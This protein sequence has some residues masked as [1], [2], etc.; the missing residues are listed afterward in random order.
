MT[1]RDALL[2]GL[3]RRHG[4]TFT[5]DLGLDQSRN[6]PS[7]LFRWLC[8]ALLASARIS[9]DI[10]LK[11]AE[12]LAKAGWTPPRKLVDGT[13]QARV[14]ALGR[15]GYVRCDEST[16]RELGAL[17]EKVLGDYGGDLRRLR[18]AA[19]RDPA[20]E[21][22]LLTEFTG[23]G[24]VGADI[25]LREVQ[26]AWDELHPCADR[27][28][29]DAAKRLGLPETAEGL[30]ELV[31]RADFPRLVAALVRADLAGEDAES[32]RKAAG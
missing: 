18:T 2:D 13:W 26:A 20:A 9:A 19:E 32:L 25:F 16:S 11:A 24:P 28:A 15:A 30:A 14:D 12:E 6:T 22:R 17:A 1:A 10:A 29:L 21:R 27:R 7:V 31:P 4:R 23:V 5:E 8:A 3:M